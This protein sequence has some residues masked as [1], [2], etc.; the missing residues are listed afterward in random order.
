MTLLPITLAGVW[1]FE[2]CMLSLRFYLLS[3]PQVQ[4]TMKRLNWL[5]P[6][7]AILFII[8][9]FSSACKVK[10]NTGLSGVRVIKSEIKADEPKPE[11]LDAESALR[12]SA[13]DYAKQYIGSR[14]KYAGR[15]PSGFDC[16]GFTSYVLKQQ[17]VS[18]SPASRTQATEGREVPL[19]QVKPGD[20][21]FF[22]RSGKGGSVT[23]VAMVIDNKPDGIYVIHSTSS[24]GVMIDNISTSAYWKPKTLFAR[25]VISK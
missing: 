15:D 4:N 9:L 6:G 13:V 17:N 24:R 8:L 1:F 7:I 5:N 22:S 16:S 23:H 2:N 21:V 19:S 12:Y 25:D 20:L 3:T 18:V 11:A 14:Y 10:R